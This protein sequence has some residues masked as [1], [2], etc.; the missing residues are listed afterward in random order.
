[1]SQVKDCCDLTEIRGI[2]GGSQTFGCRVD[3]GHFL[4]WRDGTN[5]WYSTGEGTPIKAGHQETIPHLETTCEIHHINEEDN[6][7]ISGTREKSAVGDSTEP[8]QF[9]PLVYPMIVTYMK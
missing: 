6:V 5:S 8:K 7:L 1:V 4:A 9:R 3:L 2:P